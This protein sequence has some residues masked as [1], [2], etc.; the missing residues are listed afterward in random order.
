MHN[1]PVLVQFA[2][3][4]VTCVYFH[5]STSFML[6]M[7]SYFFFVFLFA[8]RTLR[9]FRYNLTDNDAKAQAY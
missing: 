1:R 6:S 7:N 8:I 3:E 5:H 9:S 4:W 2:V